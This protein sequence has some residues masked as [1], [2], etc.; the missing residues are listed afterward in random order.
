MEADRDRY[1]AMGHKFEGKK[2]IAMIDYDAH[3]DTILFEAALQEMQNETAAWIKKTNED[4]SKA[5]SEI[6][7]VRAQ[8]METDDSEQ[9]AMQYTPQGRGDLAML[10]GEAPADT[11]LLEANL[12]EMQNETE[13]WIKETNDS[14]SAIEKRRAHRRHTKLSAQ[15][16]RQLKTEETAQTAVKDA[17]IMH[18]KEPMA[19]YVQIVRHNDVLR[20]VVKVSCSNQASGIGR[21]LLT[22]C[23]EP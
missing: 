15:L 12:R 11:R 1:E 5:S 23:A 18:L 21:E 9:D 19:A 10:D 4:N 22:N 7:K 20:D 14:N 17:M 2:D 16:R 6:E 8:A 13:A 3:A